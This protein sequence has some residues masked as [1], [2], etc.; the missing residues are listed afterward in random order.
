MPKVNTIALSPMRLG[1]ALRALA[2]GFAA[3]P[4]GH[5]RIGG[6]LG[7]VDPIERGPP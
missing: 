2:A 4:V 5:H 1:S 3:R 7:Q 6:I